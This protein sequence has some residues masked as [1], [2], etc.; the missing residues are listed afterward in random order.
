MVDLRSSSSVGTGNRVEVSVARKWESLG[1][2]ETNRCSGCIG[3][4]A[5]HPVQQH[6]G[7]EESVAICCKKPKV[8]LRATAASHS[9]SRP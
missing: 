3:H 5:S 6:V 9:G 8:R 7:T 1:L 4:I 2:C